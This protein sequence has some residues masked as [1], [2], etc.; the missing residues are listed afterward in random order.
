MTSVRYLTCICYQIRK[1]VAKPWYVLKSTK[2]DV[3]EKKI[4]LAINENLLKLSD[5]KRKIDEK[6]EYLLTN[7]E[8]EI[9]KEYDVIRW[10]Q[11]FPP[12]TPFKIKNLVNISS[13]F[14][15]S[16]LDNLKS[17][18]RKQDEQILVVQSK[19]LQFSLA[20]LL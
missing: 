3:I 16:L 7:P 9:P 12:L 6:N 10:T 13:E 19:I 17:G 4:I 2:E 14:K 8:E 11:F 18:M 20:H 5:V 15:K 1:N